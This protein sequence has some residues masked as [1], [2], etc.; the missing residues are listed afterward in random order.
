MI[1]EKPARNLV[2]EVVIDAA[3]M[4]RPWNEPWNTTT[5]GRPV[6]C[7]ASRSAASTASLPELLKKTESS[8]SGSTSPSRSVS[9]SSGRCMTVVY[10]PWISLATCSWAAATT[11][12]WQ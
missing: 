7:R 4:V 5:L 3:P 2:P 11:R 10:C 8:R 1:G 9:V 6:A 12:G